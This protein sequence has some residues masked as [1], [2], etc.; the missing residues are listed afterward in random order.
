MFLNENP[1]DNNGT[2][3]LSSPYFVAYFIVWYYTDQLY[4]F[5]AAS[6]IYGGITPNSDTPNNFYSYGMALLLQDIYEIISIQ[7]LTTT[8]QASTNQDYHVASASELYSLLSKSNS[9]IS[10]N[11][12]GNDSV[13][14]TGDDCGQ[15]YDSS[16]NALVSF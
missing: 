13:L 16:G 1:T 14:L 2:A 7:Y 15:I 12:V 6:E 3:M 11:M 9:N 5:M 8:T 4:H 10:L